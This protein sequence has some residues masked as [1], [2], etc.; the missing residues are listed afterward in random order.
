MQPRIADGSARSAPPSQG[1]A[2]AAAYSRW[3]CALSAPV[4]GGAQMQPRMADGS[5]RSAPPSRGRADTAAYSRWE[6][7]LS[8]PVPGA[9][10]CSHVWQMGV[11]AQRPRPGGAQ[12]QPRMADGSARSAPPSRG[13]ADAATYGRWECALSAPVPGAR[14]PNMCSPSPRRGR[15]RHCVILAAMQN[16]KCKE[17]VR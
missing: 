3:E 13:H 5:A 15:E 11:R 16:I 8:A 2:D 9:R 7:A 12:M 17:I 6:C 4:P 14:T 10:K 1:R